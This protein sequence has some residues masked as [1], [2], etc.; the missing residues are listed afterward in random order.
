MICPKCQMP[1]PEGWLEQHRTWCVGAPAPTDVGVWFQA[2][3]S[4]GW[5][6]NLYAAGTVSAVKVD[7]VVFRPERAVLNG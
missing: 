5:Y 7:G 3:A 1:V 6:Q 2:S 4:G